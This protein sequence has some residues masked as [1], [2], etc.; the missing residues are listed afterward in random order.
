MWSECLNE[1][2]QV[3]SVTQAISDSVDPNA[4]VIIA[5]EKLSLRISAHVS[6]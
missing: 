4:H 2:S 6:F 3:E 5:T 1:Y